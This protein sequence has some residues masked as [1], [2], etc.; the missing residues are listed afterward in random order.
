MLKVKVIV[1]SEKN[2][3]IIRSQAKGK[4]WAIAKRKALWSQRRL[5]LGDRK[6]LIVLAWCEKLILDFI[7]MWHLNIRFT[8]EFYNE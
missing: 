4:L 3:S 6:Y 8:L 7:A 5:T 2:I 1:W